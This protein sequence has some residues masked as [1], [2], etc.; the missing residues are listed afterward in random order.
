MKKCASCSKDLPDAALHCVFCGA[1]QAPASS[2]KTVM[3]YQASDVLDQIR[4]QQGQA[5]AARPVAPPPVVAQRPGGSAPPPYVAPAAAHAATMVAPPNAGYGGPSQGTPYVPPMGPGP[6][7]GPMS[8]G[9]IGPGPSPYPH[10]AGGFPPSG[11]QPYPQA[12]PQP[13]PQAPPMPATPV[14]PVISSYQG[15]QPTAH[16]GRPIEPWNH[17]L[18]IV[19]IVW[20]A[21]LLLAFVA[22]RMTEPALAFGWNEMLDADGLAKLPSLLMATV[23]LISVLLGILSVPTVARGAI[24]WILALVAIFIS[25]L[26]LKPAWQV[27]VLAAGMAFMV[28]GLVIRHEYRDALLPRI[29][30]TLAA[31]LIVLPSV[32]PDGG[33][34]ELVES[35]KAL[36][37]GPIKGHVLAQLVAIFLAVLSLLVW[38]P[39]P[40]SGLAKPLAWL[41]MAWPLV[42]LALVFLDDGD[43]DAIT[44]HPY[45]A[46]SWIAGMLPGLGTAYLAIAGYAGAAVIGKQLE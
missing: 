5:A 35:F 31:I 7:P 40:S 36:I 17:S 27:Y 23:G 2:N 8:G 10:A 33:R 12:P 3:G 9:P 13:Y 41:F 42:L 14:A 34:I 18:R 44:K 15:S 46:A 26:A 11:P 45:V 22:P 38:L 4:R 24:G 21:L 29:I 30:V 16:T 20:G 1:K 25:P 32:I 28:T 37:D 19:Q 6:G 39:A 43:V